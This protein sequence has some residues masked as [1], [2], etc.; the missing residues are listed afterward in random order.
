[1]NIQLMKQSK[2]HHFISRSYQVALL[3]ERVIITDNHQLVQS[4]KLPLSL[5]TRIAK[6]HKCPY[7]SK[8]VHKNN[9]SIASSIDISSIADNSAMLGKTTLLTS[10]S[11]FAP[12]KL[13]KNQVFR[14]ESITLKNGNNTLVKP[15]EI[16]KEDELFISDS[17]IESG[18][19]GTKFIYSATFAK[20]LNIVFGIGGWCLYPLEDIQVDKLN[21][22]YILSRKFGIVSHESLLFEVYSEF[23]FTKRTVKYG[24]ESLRSKAISLLAQKAGLGLYVEH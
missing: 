9:Q 6:A 3:K 7:R 11:A 16:I 23:V 4:P 20:Y 1:M 2:I 10:K 22:G 18:A 17:D 5:R 24:V 14:T 8:K 15:F 21:Q 12:S 13:L 19:N